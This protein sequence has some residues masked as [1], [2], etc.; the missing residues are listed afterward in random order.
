MKNITC[1]NCIQDFR[2]GDPIK[3]TDGKEI[4]LVWECPYCYTPLYIVQ[5]DPV[6]LSADEPVVKLSEEVKSEHKK[7]I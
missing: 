4:R 2:A 6:K 7:Q 3:I 5:P 1:P